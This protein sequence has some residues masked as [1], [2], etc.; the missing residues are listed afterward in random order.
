MQYAACVPPITRLYQILSV[1]GGFPLC[2]EGDVTKTKV[3]GK[4]GSSD[5]R[6]T[7]TY[8]N[9]AQQTYS[10]AGVG[11]VPATDIGAPSAGGVAKP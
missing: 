9:G 2:S 10:L 4:L 7:M 8:T 1:G 3:R 11:A 5:Y 6:V